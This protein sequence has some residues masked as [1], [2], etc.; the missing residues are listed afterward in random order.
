MG[1]SN[2]RRP[3][4]DSDEVGS[5]P[6]AV[7]RST[8]ALWVRNICALLIAGF[9]GGFIATVRLRRSMG[10]FEELRIVTGAGAVRGFVTTKPDG[11]PRVMLLDAKGERIPLSLQVSP[12]GGSSMTLQDH[13]G[14]ARIR[15]EMDVR[16]G[17][18]IKLF[19]AKGAVIW[20]AP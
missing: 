9:A 7:A 15:L 20:Q 18:S 2:T 4:H 10:D 14:T 5:P 13:A 16:L 17:P 11:A 19:D 12:H 1:R 6:A 3:P 8:V